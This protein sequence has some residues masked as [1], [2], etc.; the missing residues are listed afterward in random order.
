[1]KN[2]I[3]LA[4]IFLSYFGFSQENCLNGIDDNNDGF[5]DL[6]DPLCNCSIS[7][8]QSIIPNHSFENYSSLPTYFSQLNLATPW[9]QATN[10]TTDYYNTA[11]YLV[12][13][14]SALLVPF[15]DG[16]GVVGTFYENN[17]KEYLGSSLLNPMIA[18]TN[19][20]LKFNIAAITI[21]EISAY[22]ITNL[23]NLGPVNV[24]IY[25]K[26]GS[27][28]FPLNTV[29][30]PVSLD[31][32]WVVL[33]Q[34]SYNPVT[35]WGELTI[36]F[37]P[38]FNVNTIMIGAPINLPSTY[39]DYIPFNYSSYRPYM[40]YDNLR[41]STT[42][43][44]GA[45]ITS[46]GN[47]CE[48]NLVLSATPIQPGFNY[49]W[50]FNGVA[51]AGAT[52][53]SYN[54]PYSV[55]NLGN[56]N[57]R[58]YQNNVCANSPIFNINANIIT[59][60][61]TPIAPICSGGTLNALPITSNNGISGTWTPA[62]NNL[63][64]T[65]YT[66]TPNAGQCANNQT[67]EI[68]VNP[69][70]TPSFTPIT[71]ICSGGTLN[72]LPI[73]SNNGISGTWTPALNNLLTTTYTFTPNAGQCA[74]NQ[75]MEIVVNPIITPSFTP[76]APIC[77]G[78][79]L[80]ALPIT[81]NNG[82]S[83]TWTPALNNLLTTTY[84]FTPNAGQCAN[85]QTM[86]IVVNPIITPSFTPIAPICS[87]GTL[88]ALPTTSNN[89]IS[90]TWTPALN[91]LVTTTY[92]FTPN[93]GQCTNNQT[94]EIVV[95][96][97]PSTPLVSTPVNYCINQTSVQLSATG[98][99][100]LWYNSISGGFGSSNAP[101][102]NTS[103]AG[104]INYYVTQTIDG[105]ESIR[106]L[107]QVNIS[108]IPK[109]IVEPEYT[110]CTGDLTNVQLSSNVSDALFY[111]S[112]ISGNIDGATTGNGLASFTNSILSLQAGIT[113]PTTIVYSVIASVNG[114]A[115]PEEFFKIIVNP[116][117]TINIPIVNSPICSGNQLDIN[118]T[119]P[120]VNTTFSWNVDLAVTNGV[121]GFTQGTG[122]KI[123]DTLFTTGIN[124]GTV[125]YIITP[126]INNCRGDVV[127]ITILVNPLPTAI[128]NNNQPAICS[129]NSPSFIVDSFNP[130]TAFIYSVNQVGVS[131]ATGGNTFTNPNGQVMIDNQN[132]INTGTSQ[133]YVEYLF[134]PILN[135]CTG[136][137]VTVK[138]PVN[139]IPI[140]ILKDGHICKDSSGNVYQNY[141][142][143]TGL[144]SNTHTFIWKFT[145]NLG[146]TT[147]LPGIT[148]TQIAT[149]VGLYSVI[150]THTTTGCVSN[151]VSAN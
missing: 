65:T 40:I 9:Q 48:N 67:M 20:Q 95:K 142:L 114:C 98:S 70:I 113:L 107:I 148:N 128:A 137:I 120:F 33:G 146:I 133:G 80:N 97:S 91:N 31:P 22:N 10:A 125:T 151:E 8:T 143:E 13:G 101:T 19:Y 123:T 96:S 149:T 49:Q 83:G 81:S 1:M 2:I 145:N 7:Q 93:A 71:P 85:N 139:P 102:P 26:S 14:L 27:A 105:C 62:L 16:A 73:T 68:V 108:P 42:I 57:V 58:I 60:S 141:V 150:A 100:L 3:T 69:I 29:N 111:W 119:S 106:K 36:N 15:P 23:P 99:N 82:I 135:N 103:V 61:F 18:G 92:T 25:G 45:S 41:L 63:L 138:V 109:V 37:T 84:T 129:G 11:G 56:Y 140:P 52:N 53:S 104:T 51:I 28:T 136:N 44:T 115:G 94:M 12:T 46:S 17:W 30:D 75:T 127:R 90:G 34:A 110:I 74:N 78:G 86:E 122:A 54:V 76:I 89:G 5:I 21:L 112:I 64:T 35:S 66:F 118:L 132:L 117:P 43:S 39:P 126:T 130:N 50:Y 32:S 87:G 72:A 88:N 144:S 77:S 79:T 121:T 147:T 47:F 124:Q 4:F 131:G 59:P 55:N 6:N 116:K 134:T 24:T 38:T